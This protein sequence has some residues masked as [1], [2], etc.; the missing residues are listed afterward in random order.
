MG[1]KSSKSKDATAKGSKERKSL[2]VELEV[3]LRGILV[4]GGAPR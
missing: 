4:E 1:K 3:R 2:P